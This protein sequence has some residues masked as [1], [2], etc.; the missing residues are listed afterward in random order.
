MHGTAW[1]VRARIYL[2]RA[3]LENLEEIAHRLGQLGLVVLD[4]QNIIRA[5]VTNGLNI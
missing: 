1:P 2:R 3:L 4:R 5:P